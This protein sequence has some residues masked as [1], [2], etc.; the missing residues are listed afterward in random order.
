MSKLV[1]HKPF[2]ILFYGFPGCGKTYFARQFCE[3]VQAAHLQSDR[4]RSELF[5][6]PRYDKSENRAVLQIVD[7][8]VEEFLNA[9]VSVVYDMGALRLAQR[10]QLRDMAR[11][12]GVEV[13]LIW[14]QIDPESAVSRAMKR[15]RRR[16]DDKYAM[17]MDYAS[18]QK[19]AGS[20]QNPE[21]GE[22]YVVTSGKHAFPMQMNSVMRVLMQKNIITPS[23]AP[24]AV[25][26]PGLINLIP[27]PNIGR[28]DMGRRNISIR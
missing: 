9:G 15:D 10:R 3:Q 28:V 1:P 2:L 22:Q 5:E 19:I 6:E 4:I 21:L 25:A 26:K 12:S 18:F 20:M 27:N 11:K 7:Y 13:V 14:Q 24:G 23:H 17:H 16:A 8:M